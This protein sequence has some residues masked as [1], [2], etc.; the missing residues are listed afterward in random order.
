MTHFSFVRRCM[1]DGVP[2]PTAGG[3]PDAKPM[4]DKR[5]LIEIVVET[6]RGDSNVYE[7]DARAQAARLTAVRRGHEPQPFERGYVANSLTTYGEP[8]PGLLAI[9]LPTFEGCRVQGRIL[10]AL[11]RDGREKAEVVIVAVA[12]ADTRLAAVQDR[13]ELASTAAAF[14]EAELR[15]GAR[16]LDADTASELAHTARRRWVLAHGNGETG[17]A[18]PAWQMHEDDAVLLRHE[19]GTSR[20]SLAEAR[21]YTLPLRFQK[22][23][24]ALLAPYERILLWVYRPLMHQARFG[25]FG[26]QVLR[27][28]I[29]VITDQQFLWMCDPVTPSHMVEGYGY[30]ARM[31]ALERL[32][33]VHLEETAQG[34]RLN[35]ELENGCSKV[36]M[37]DI[38]FPSEAHA[39][40]L[41]ATR[42]LEGF[43]PRNHEMRLVRRAPL[44][45]WS[46]EL[47]DP[48][49]SE[50]ER[51]R[52][53]VKR[54]QAALEKELAAE[55]IYAQAFI[56]DWGEAK[57]LTVT[58][59][60]VRLTP[61]PGSDQKATR[62][63][64][65]AIGSVEICNSQL[66][67]WFRVWLP[68]SGKHAP[69]KGEGLEKWEMSFPV[70]FAR[71][72]GECARVL[73]V[74]LSTLDLTHFFRCST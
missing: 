43:L 20:F 16:W 18:T 25:L 40:L 39:D 24:G 56:P 54:L 37:F 26:R 64:L 62:I 11:E 45:P 22:Y 21:L 5:R 72:F 32:G 35:V 63:P 23:V 61:D 8:L 59:R 49:T 67:S 12:E 50:H 38:E 65:D 15:A 44:E 1:P 58:D 10:G 17:Q 71:E 70:V 48:T 27:Q 55:T 74:L 7:W 57:L 2:N 53:T 36:E 13:T 41:E 28:G 73:R 68:T 31:F 42:V 34:W 9:S 14:L 3:F 29:L 66:G 51:T 30:V 19:S 52:T 6:P 46:R 4:S 47:T 60:F 33:A 69:S